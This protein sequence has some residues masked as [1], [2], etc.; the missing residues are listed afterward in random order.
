MKFTLLDSLT[1]PGNPAKPNDDA[2][3][4]VDRAGIVMDGATGLAAPLMPGDSDAAWL[5]HLGVRLLMG[6]MRGPVAARLAL[7]AVLNQVEYAY[8]TGRSRAPAATYEMPFASMM[9]VAETA[10]GFEAL[11]FGDCAALV[12]RP[13]APVE[14]LGQAFDA[15]AQEAA[16]AARLAKAKGLNPASATN[17]PAF[18]EALRTSRNRVNT[19]QGHWLFGPDASAADHVATRHIA[20]P[21]GTVVLL[22]TDGFLALASDYRRYDAE[23]LIAAAQT[24]GLKI[25][26][27]E[28]RA[29][30][31]GDPEGVVYPR[32]KT[33]D[34]ATALLLRLG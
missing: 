13:Q 10:T 2:F 6:F 25:L 8:V 16:G 26:G 5:S 15:R 14:I 11:S 19:D 21:P 30:E 22:M 1:L 33:S 12:K 29:I 24:K 4:H 9:F 17:L 27:D 23:G 32:F 18:M 28:L 7:N 3:G 20:A 31:A 34:D